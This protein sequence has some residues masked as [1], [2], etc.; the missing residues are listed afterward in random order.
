MTYRDRAV[1]REELLK[2]V[3]RGTCPTDDVLSQAIAELRRAFR[4]SARDARYIETITK[5]GYR[6][7]APVELAAESPA[8]ATRG[9]APAPGTWLLL[10]TGAAVIALLVALLSSRQI[11]QPNLGHSAGLGAHVMPVTTDPGIE[12]YPAV[13]ADGS[14][15]VYAARGSTGRDFDLFVTTIGSPGRVA[16]TEDPSSSDYMATWSPDGSQVAFL[17][18]TDGDCGIHV[19]PSSRSGDPA[20]SACANHCSHRARPH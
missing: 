14:R 11:A 16:L 1:S 17:R 3:W 18:L 9:F 8:E 2:E 6:L 20:P 4:D 10:G 13:S 19:V 5:V 15:V 12:L 7:V